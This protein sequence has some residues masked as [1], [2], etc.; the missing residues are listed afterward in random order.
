VTGSLK[1]YKSIGMPLFT[2]EA[3]DKMLGFA[4]REHVTVP[5]L[6]DASPYPSLT[7][8]PC[9]YFFLAPKVPFSPKN[10]V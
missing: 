9:L 7:T 6:S 3:R 8:V 4:N 2:D 1:C 10:E 5:G